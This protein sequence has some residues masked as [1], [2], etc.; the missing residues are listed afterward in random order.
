MSVFSEDCK[1]PTSIIWALFSDDK[2]RFFHSVN[3]MRQP[4]SGR[5]RAVS[6]F[7]HANFLVCGLRKSDENFIVSI[8]EPGISLKFPA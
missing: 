3:L 7:T 8:G 1:R 6:K 4:T 2:A 5:E